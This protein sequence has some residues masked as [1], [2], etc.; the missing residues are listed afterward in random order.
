MRT[1]EIQSAVDT[2]EVTSLIESPYTY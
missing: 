1:D 2:E